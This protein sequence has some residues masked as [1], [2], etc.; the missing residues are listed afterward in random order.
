MLALR[1]IYQDDES[2]ISYIQKWLGYAATGDVREDQVGAPIGPGGN[3]KTL[4]FGTA[5]QVLGTYAHSM[6]AEALM[7]T[8]G[9]AI[10]E[11][12]VRLMGVRMALA[13]EIAEGR[14]WN[15]TRLKLLSGRDPIPARDVRKS[16]DFLPT[17]KLII[18]GNHLPGLRTVD[19]AITDRIGSSRTWSRSAAPDS[20]SRAWTSSWKKMWPYIL[21]WIIEGTQ[22]WL[23]EGLKPPEVVMRA[24]ANYFN[25]EDETGG[26]LS[27]CC[28]PWPD[29]PDVP[30][31]A[32]RSR[33][34]TRRWSC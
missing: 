22:K 9:S 34:T 1:L 20:R 32:E 28:A 17:H 29:G 30:L 24:T 21:R 14:N 23:R 16:F 13:S 11:E 10:P 15:E 27:T 26:W 12:L 31:D 19:A 7:E 2:A 4:V 8:Y 33:P 6:A 25:A 5:R 3:G 18:V